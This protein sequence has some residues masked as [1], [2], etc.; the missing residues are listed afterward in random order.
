MHWLSP[1]KI[2]EKGAEARVRAR[3]RV[4]EFKFGNHP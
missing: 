2:L 1:R 4:Q 3:S